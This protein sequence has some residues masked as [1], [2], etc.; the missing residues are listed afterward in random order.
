MLNPYGFLLS[1]SALLSLW[2]TKQRAK[3]YMINSQ[4]VENI[5][6]LA[7][8]GAVVGARAYHVI[9]KWG[10]YQANPQ[11]ILYVWQ[12]GLGIFGA[13][14]GG[15]MAT[16]IYSKLAKL[17]SL[18]V[19]DL[20]TP[21]LPLSQFIGRFGNYFNKEGFGPP[22]DLPWKV[23]IPVEKRP[24]QFLASQYF[25]PTFFYESILSLI[26]FVLLLK[27]SGRLQDKQ[28]ALFGVYL[29]GYG[30]I[31]SLTEVFRFDT[32]LFLGIKTA[33]L[34]SLIFIFTGLFL[35][36]RKSRG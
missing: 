23:F 22:T 1:L 21:A 6:L 28:G 13:L 24:E 36:L 11:E 25:H 10:Y 9:D 30:L 27:Y 17:N 35:I 19:L 3:L 31:R 15:L 8:L 2:L 14:G 12:G 5:F 33:H 4:Q 16:L 34:F 26:L 7:I 29:V 18:K 20:V 32:A